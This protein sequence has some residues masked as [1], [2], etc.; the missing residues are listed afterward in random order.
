[1]QNP[2]YKGIAVNKKIAFERAAYTSS[3]LRGL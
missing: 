1:M 2:I 3:G